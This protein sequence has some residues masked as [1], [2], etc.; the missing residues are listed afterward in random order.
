MRPEFHQQSQSGSVVIPVV[1]RLDVQQKR[2]IRKM[3]F[4]NLGPDLRFAHLDPQIAKP[5]LVV[6]RGRHPF[7][8]CRVV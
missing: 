8:K 1:H 7:R 5:L 2:A 3:G 4:R 6:H